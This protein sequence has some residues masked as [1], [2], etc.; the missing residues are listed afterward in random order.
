MSIFGGWLQWRDVELGM[1]HRPTFD[2]GLSSEHAFAVDFLPSTNH[3][4]RASQVWLPP[5][6]GDRARPAAARC[7]DNAQREA[8]RTEQRCIHHDPSP[9][10][11]P[12]SPSASLSFWPTPTLPPEPETG[13]WGRAGTGRWGRSHGTPRNSFSRSTTV[14]SFDYMACSFVLRRNLG[15]DVRYR[16]I[17]LHSLELESREGGHDAGHRQDNEQRT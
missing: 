8:P 15:A 5:R 16:S 10:F 17:R 13:P 11:S 12:L 7:S 3:S 4:D 14:R 6:G 1:R 2:I 9:L